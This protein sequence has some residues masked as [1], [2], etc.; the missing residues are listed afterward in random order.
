MNNFF[1]RYKVDFHI[2]CAIQSQIV[3]FLNCSTHEYS[4]MLWTLHKGNSSD[5][6]T[7]HAA[8]N[9]ALHYRFY[10]DQFIIIFLFFVCGARLAAGVRLSGQNIIWLAISHSYFSG[11]RDECEWDAMSNP[12]TVHISIYIKR[13]RFKYSMQK[14][15]VYKYALHWIPESL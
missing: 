11:S 12:D 8:K 10:S 1:A 14:F 6:K 3:R 13:F 7:I 4:N 5:A 15:Y 2:F 9:H